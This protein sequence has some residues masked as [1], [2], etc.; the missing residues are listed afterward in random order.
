M[1][2]TRENLGEAAG[3]NSNCPI[4]VLQCEEGKKVVKNVFEESSVDLVQIVILFLQH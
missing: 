1:S 3:V 4:V 2:V